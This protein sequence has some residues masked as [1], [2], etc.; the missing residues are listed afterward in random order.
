MAHVLL[1]VSVI[2]GCAM[3]LFLEDRIRL[4]SLEFGLEIADGV[5]VRA[6]IGTTTG[7]GEVVAIILGLVTRSAPEV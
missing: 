5:T 2:L 6:A 1:Q 7:I 3:E 4:D